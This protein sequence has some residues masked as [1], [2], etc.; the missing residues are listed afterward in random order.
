LVTTN[1]HV[2]ASNDM[3]TPEEETAQLAGSLDP[4]AKPKVPEPLPPPTTTWGFEPTTGLVEDSGGV[5]DK[6]SGAW[7]N[8]V[9]VAVVVALGPLI[10]A[11]CALAR[12]VT[13]STVA[14]VT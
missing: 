3:T 10:V 7:D 13:S 14:S 4:S 5:S 6:K 8:S 9:K 1:G 12:Y 2:T 11:L